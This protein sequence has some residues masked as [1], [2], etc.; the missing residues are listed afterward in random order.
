MK[1]PIEFQRNR[2]DFTSIWLWYFIKRWL[3]LWY[4]IKFISNFEWCK[5]FSLPLKLSRDY[6]SNLPKEKQVLL[7]IEF[8]GRDEDE[9]GVKFLVQREKDGKKGGRVLYSL[10]VV[11]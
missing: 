2:F 3:Y 8:A 9:E 10:E 6:Y 1:T 11:P 5:C 4:K 7:N